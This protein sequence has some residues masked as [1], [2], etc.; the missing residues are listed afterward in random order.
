M[1]DYWMVQQTVIDFLV[2]GCSLSLLFE[3]QRV[4]LKVVLFIVAYIW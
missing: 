3:Q 4:Q 1:I 2:F